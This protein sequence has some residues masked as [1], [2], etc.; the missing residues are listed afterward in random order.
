MFFLVDGN[1]FFVSC[2][3]VMNPRLQNKPVVVTS[4]NEG[5]IISRSNEAKA[6]GLKMGEPLFK[7]KRL[8]QLHQVIVLASNHALYSDVSQ[9]IIHILRTVTP[10]IEPYSIDESFL[11]MTHKNPELLGLTIKQR[12]QKET[13]IPVGVGIGKTKTLA[14]VANHCAKKSSSGVFNIHQYNEDKVLKTIFIN[15]L[16]GVG[17]QYESKLKRQRIFTALHVKNAPMALLKASCQVHGQRLKLELSGHS[18]I[19]LQTQSKP[20]QSIICS[21]SFGAASQSPAYIQAA[22][23]ENIRRA[24]RKCR[25]QGLKMKHCHIFLHRCRF[26]YGQYYRGV[27]VPLPVY[28]SADPFIIQAAIS[29]L[30]T[31]MIDTESYVKSGVIIN[32]LCPK[33]QVPVHLLE[34]KEEKQQTSLDRVMVAVDKLNQKWGLNTVRVGQSLTKASQKRGPKDRLILAR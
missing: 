25:K 22:L 10:D 14:K 11:Y 5:C 33:Q 24:T 29:A 27:D 32:T 16:W 9:R 2:E 23:T 31:I 13:G 15:H 1:N 8:V 21:R 18:A 26:T 6:I 3:R 34:T 17:K 7:C 28:S 30:K 12:I 19:P 20:N 4:N